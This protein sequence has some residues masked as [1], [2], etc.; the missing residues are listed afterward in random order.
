MDVQPDP[1]DDEELEE[2]S[3]CARSMCGIDAWKWF[4][5]VNVMSSRLA[6]ENNY[7]RTKT[8]GA[9]TAEDSKDTWTDAIRDAI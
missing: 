8:N 3:S 1:S 9:T 6:Q 5:R 7:E 4:R 2:E